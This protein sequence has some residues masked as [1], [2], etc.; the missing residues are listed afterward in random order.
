M[1]GSTPGTRTHKHVA[2]R[3]WPLLK[4][5]ERS[6][7][8]WQLMFC[9]RIYEEAASSACTSGFVTHVES[10]SPPCRGGRSI[11]PGTPDCQDQPAFPAIPANALHRCVW[12]VGPVTPG[13]HAT[14][15]QASP[16][17]PRPWDPCPQPEGGGK[18][19]LLDPGHVDPGHAGTF[20][21]VSP[22]PASGPG[23]G[24][25]RR[26]PAAITASRPVAA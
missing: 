22:A 20:H 25:G 11:R 17:R 7:R 5:P 18:C 19:G 21:A 8:R 23:R 10:M 1:C 12:R 9:S 26:G 14:E 13:G 6:C 4:Q 2:V 3:G 24:G 15:R 16:S